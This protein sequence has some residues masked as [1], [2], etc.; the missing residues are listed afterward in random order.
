MEVNMTGRER[1][2]ATFERKQTDRTP[3]W[4]GNPIDEQ[5]NKIA[6]HF[7]TTPH[8]LDL[9]ETL[10]DDM[11]WLMAD[12]YCWKHPDQRPFFDFRQGEALH[13]LGE[14]GK[15]KDAQSIK[16]IEAFEW[17]NMQYLDFSEYRELLLDA[18]ARGFA[19]AGGFWSPF[20]HNMS[21]FLGMENY[22]IKMYTHP[23]LVAYL[24]NKMVE[25]YLEAN[26]LCFEAVGDLIDIFFFGN[27]FGTQNDLLVS[28]EAFDTFVLP[29]F[30]QLVGLG[31]HYGKYVMLHSCGSIYRVIPKLIATGIHALHPLQALAAKMSADELVQYKDQLIFCGAVDAQ[32]L[33][34]S[35]TPEEIH[36]TIR[37]LKEKLGPGFIVSPSH[38]ALMTDVSM[39]NVTALSEAATG[40]L[41]S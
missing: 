25:C 7:N 15:L 34:P 18:R 5:A 8:P 41:L 16:D 39:A 29:Y 3:F 23:E 21:D 2:I 13:H 24:T 32:H 38:E 37:Q 6:A 36:R 11:V 20:F 1:I 14:G 17:P 27:D 9:S 22:F 26:R 10:N 12:K 35:G 30:K 19:V 40:I 4:K 33:L 31:N 28:P